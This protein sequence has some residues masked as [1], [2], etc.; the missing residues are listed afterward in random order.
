MGVELW[1]TLLSALIGG[2]GLAGSLIL[3]PKIRAERRK[4]N[5][6]TARLDVETGDAM[7]ARLAREIKRL[8]T[9]LDE[10]RTQF[11]T[12]RSLAAEREHDL[13]RENKRLRGE[14]RRLT[15]RVDG[16]ENILKLHPPS[17]E[18][19]ELIDELDRKTAEGAAK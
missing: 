4:I 18:M 11:A 8:D 7:L 5:A 3:L 15:K 19:Q 16:L 13:E 1:V 9:E 14:V 10:V 2:G 12:F 17:A 6:E